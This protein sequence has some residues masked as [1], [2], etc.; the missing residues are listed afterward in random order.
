M[1]GE[2]HIRMGRFDEALAM[3]LENLETFRSSEG[4]RSASVG[5]TLASIASTLLSQGKIATDISE[6]N[7]EGT[8]SVA[9]RIAAA[10]D[11]CRDLPETAL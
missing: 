6:G 4:E 7:A 2:L 8:D 10:S 5:L 11:T 9:L 3:Q 1:L